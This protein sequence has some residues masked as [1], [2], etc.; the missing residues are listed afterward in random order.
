M[1][2]LAKGS[3]HHAH[4]GRERARC[5]KPLQFLTAVCVSYPPNSNSE[6]AKKDH[7]HRKICRP[8]LVLLGGSLT[9]RLE[10]REGAA[11]ADCVIVEGGMGAV[12]GRDLQKSLSAPRQKSERGEEGGTKPF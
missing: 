1:P 11:E 9:L 5:R 12:D 3:A 7:D 6:C 4:D 8:L 10:E 2:Y